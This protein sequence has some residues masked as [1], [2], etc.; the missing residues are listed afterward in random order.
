MILGRNAILKSCLWSCRHSRTI[1]I[2]QIL[3]THLSHFLL[4]LF[5]L[6]KIVYYKYFCHPPFFHF[7]NQASQ[8]SDVSVDRTDLGALERHDHTKQKL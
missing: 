6:M 5:G 7:N 2:V 8:M 1:S 3:G 4:F